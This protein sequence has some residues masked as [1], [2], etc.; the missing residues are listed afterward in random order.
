MKMESE[1]GQCRR[2]LPVLPCFS[3][4]GIV[5]GGLIHMEIVRNLDL[6][7]QNYMVY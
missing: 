5:T 1:T 2:F 6:I 7:C 3:D 4:R